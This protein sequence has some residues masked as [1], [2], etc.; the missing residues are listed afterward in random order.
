MNGGNKLGEISLHCP[1]GIFARERWNIMQPIAGKPHGKLA[2]F[3]FSV[4]APFVQ[5]I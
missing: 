4:C 1:R 2:L 5:W 3:A